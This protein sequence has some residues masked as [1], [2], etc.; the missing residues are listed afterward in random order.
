MKALGAFNVFQSGWVQSIN[1]CNH[2]YNPLC[3]FQN[4]L[5]MPILSI[6]F[7]R[8]L[9]F[10]LMQNFMYAEKRKYDSK[11]VNG[12]HHV[13]TWDIFFQKKWA[14]AERARVKLAVQSVGN[15]R[16]QWAEWIWNRRIGYWA[17]R[18][19]ARSFARTAHSFDCSALLAPLTRSAA[20]IRSFARSL[21][22]S[23][24]K[25]K[26]VSDHEM[27][28]SIW[29]RLNPLGSGASKRAS[30]RANGPVLYASIFKKLTHC[31]SISY[32]FS[33]KPCC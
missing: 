22:H 30:G 6:A 8:H 1:Q 5:S 20:L 21:T 29:Y 11:F 25:L 26:E 19:S 28:A 2:C 15:E 23:I 16:A 7:I 9:L 27:N 32:S 13:L 14:H 24:P 17:I 10:G 33:P 4:S 12:P 3:S 18:S 31:A